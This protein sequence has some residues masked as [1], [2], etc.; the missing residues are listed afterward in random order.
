MR[1]SMEDGDADQEGD[2]PKVE[3]AITV[4]IPVP[5][6]SMT[7]RATVRNRDRT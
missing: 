7:N 5:W 4:R 6:S 3:A 1:C 2:A